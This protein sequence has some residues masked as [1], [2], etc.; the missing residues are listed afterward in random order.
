MKVESISIYLMYTIELFSRQ[1]K[2]NAKQGDR[3]VYE[4]IWMLGGRK[5][6]D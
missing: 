4:V 1:G 6:R 2:E 3:Q 5:E